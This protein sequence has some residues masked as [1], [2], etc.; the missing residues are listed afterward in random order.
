[1]KQCVSITCDFDLAIGKS[2]FNEIVY[3]LKD[4]RDILMLRMLQQILM[5]YD[6][7]NTGKRNWASKV[8]STFR[9]KPSKS[10]FAPTF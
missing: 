5:S 8:I 6:G 2:D 7:S 3:R 9:Y 1:M 10:T 4:I